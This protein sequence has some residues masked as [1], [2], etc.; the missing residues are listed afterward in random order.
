VSYVYG[1]EAGNADLHERT[2]TPML[3]KLLEG[4]N[5][6]VLLMGAT[7]GGWGAGWWWLALCGLAGLVAP[8]ALGMHWWAELA[9]GRCRC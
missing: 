3:R 5:V 2:V 8:A 7:G 1:P 6:A 4:Y 9:A